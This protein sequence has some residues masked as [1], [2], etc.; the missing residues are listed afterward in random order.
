[1]AEDKH[2]K[3][4]KEITRNIVSVEKK[5]DVILDTLDEHGEI[6]KKIPTRED[7]PELLKWTLEW[8]TLKTEHN[9]IKKILR[10]RLKVEI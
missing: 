2:S 10:E 6:L 9:Q 3:E 5:I 4:H 1:M 8:A 7:F